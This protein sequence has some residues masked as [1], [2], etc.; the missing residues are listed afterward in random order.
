M[1]ILLL[2]IIIISP[3]FI[4]ISLYNTIKIYRKIK[5]VDKYGI[6]MTATWFAVEII[7]VIFLFIRF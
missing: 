4:A 3:I 1:I 5:L 2:I 7:G 6:L